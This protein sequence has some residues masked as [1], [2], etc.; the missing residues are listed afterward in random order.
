MSA[1]RYP[2]DPLRP[3]QVPGASASETGPGHQPSSA[4]G[5]ADPPIIDE[6]NLDG[7]AGSAADQDE[8]DEPAPTF[9]AP[10][11]KQPVPR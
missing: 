11:L 8:L 10:R 2:Q 5:G 6:Q 7:Q 3:F 4:S 9:D 1:P